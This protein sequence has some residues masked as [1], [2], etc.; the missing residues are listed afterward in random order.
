M[1]RL[2]FL[3]L[4]MERKEK[5]MENQMEIVKWDRYFALYDQ[6]ELVCVTVY[7]KGAKEVKRRLE[8]LKSIIEEAQR[9]LQNEEATLNKI[10]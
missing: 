5:K 2:F 9:N 1:G 3:P 8:E 10:Q 4:L 7:K 6:G